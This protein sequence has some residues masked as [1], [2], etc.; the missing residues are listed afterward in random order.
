MARLCA[1]NKAEEVRFTARFAKNNM[2]IFLYGPDSFRLSRK[3]RQIV[4]AYRQKTKGLNFSVIDA[5]EADFGEFFSRLRQASLFEEKKLAVINNAL[6]KNFKEKLLDSAKEL[7]ASPH[8]IILCQEGKVLKTDKLLTALKKI[9]DVQEFAE[10]SGA[11]LVSWAEAEFNQYGR[12]VEPGVASLLA[13]RLGGD[14]WQLSNEIHKLAHGSGR[15]PV[16]SRDIDSALKGEVELN[17]FKTI[18][19]LAQKDKSS[20]LRLVHQHIEAGDHPLYLLAMVANQLRNLI[21]VKSYLETEGGGYDASAAARLGM[22]P[23]VF[24]KT[25]RQSRLFDLAGLKDIFGK[26]MSYDIAIKTGRIDPGVALDLIIAE[27]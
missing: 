14:L 20:A 9:G 17:I 12:A 10:L 21:S 4:D 18:D 26:L 15:G 2:I 8:N 5:P 24:S 7:A 1:K 13:E 11:K 16:G 23:F 22:H 19:A 6:D 25:T 3:L 27:I